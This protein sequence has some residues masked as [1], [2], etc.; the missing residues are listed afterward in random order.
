VPPV[1]PMAFARA[2]AVAGEGLAKLTRRPPLIA[3][4]E[5]IFLASHPV[6][7]ADRARAELGWS[8]RPAGEGFGETIATFRE[9]GLLDS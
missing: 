1:M 4:G 2:I 3:R 6:P 8:S 5:Q 9:R 7:V